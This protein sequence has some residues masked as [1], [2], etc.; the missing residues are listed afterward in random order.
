VRVP[1]APGHHRLLGRHTE[2]RNRGVTLETLNHEG[3]QPHPR[4]G[5]KQMG[6]GSV[7]GYT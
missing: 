5:V 7:H 2:P 4:G 6:Q 3:L 1:D